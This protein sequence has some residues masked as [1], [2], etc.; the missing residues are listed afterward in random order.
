MRKRWT[1]PLTTK[2]APTTM[3]TVEASSAAVSASCPSCP[4]VV[5]TSSFSSYRSG[6]TEDPWPPWNAVTA[7]FGGSGEPVLARALVRAGAR[8]DKGVLVER[9]EVTAA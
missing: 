9:E 7:S 4:R 2:S 3:V 6:V 5:R 1:K 8:C